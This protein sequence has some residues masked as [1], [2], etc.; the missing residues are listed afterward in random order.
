[1]LCSEFAFAASLLS[2]VL[3]LDCTF[4]GTHSVQNTPA[5][6]YHDIGTGTIDITLPAELG[7]SSFLWN[8]TYQNGSLVYDENSTIQINTTLQDYAFR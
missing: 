4:N 3:Q 2:T 5:L 7:M 6:Y 1:M 8:V